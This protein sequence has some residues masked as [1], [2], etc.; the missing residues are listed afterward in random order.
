MKNKIMKTVPRWA[1][2]L[3]GL[4]TLLVITLSPASSSGQDLAG[5]NRGDRI[6]GVWDSQVTITDCATGNVL[7]SFRGLG[8]FIRGGSLTQ[9]NNQPPGLG[10]PSFGQWRKLGAGHYTA[11]FRFFAFAS[12]VFS[13]VQ[14]VSRDIQLSPSDDT[15][16]SVISSEF[17]DPNGNLI[18]SGCGTET[19]TR[20]VD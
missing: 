10:S 11:T 17:F 20:V 2:S 7:G 3:L 5:Q 14:K 18:A 8:M 13:G 9:T 15:F 19:S 6:E 12:G 4:A 16:T 1:V